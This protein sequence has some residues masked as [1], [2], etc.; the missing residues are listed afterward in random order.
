MKE[1]LNLIATHPAI[2]HT[3]EVLGS[4]SKKVW[5]S[6]LWGSSRSLFIAGLNQK[7]N[8]PVLVVTSGTEEAEILFED[9]SNVLKEVIYYPAWEFPSRGIS[10]ASEILKERLNL[11]E[12]I[13]VKKYPKVVIAPVEALSEKWPALEKL[14]EYFLFI[15]Q[16][17]KIDLEDFLL[18]LTDMGYKRTEMVEEKGEFSRRGE[19]VDVFSPAFTSPLRV[20]LE[21]DKISSLGFFSVATQRSMPKGRCAEAHTGG[22][23]I[24]IVPAKESFFKKE[25]NLSEYFKKDYMFIYDEPGKISEKRSF[26]EESA[27]RPAPQ[28]R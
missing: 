4:T 20:I 19:I 3:C 1:L 15:K 10:P 18:K 22:E 2:K 17:K 23:S 5:L 7:L 21:F 16:G 26:L 27:K 11:F 24:A 9:I 25:V 14:N 12:K 28:S 13:A 8:L 6:G